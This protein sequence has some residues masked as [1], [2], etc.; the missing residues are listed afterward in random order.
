VR[1]RFL[2][3]L[4]VIA[5]HFSNAQENPYSIKKDTLKLDYRFGG[6][7]NDSL[8]DLHAGLISLNPGG[9]RS[10]VFG[11]FQL[12][13]LNFSSGLTNNFS[14][15]ENN[16]FTY[17]S[18]PHVGFHYSFGSK[19]IQ[20]LNASY[21]QFFSNKFGINLKISRNSMGTMLRNGNFKDNGVD[22]SSIYEGTHYRNFSR[23]YFN[24]I[25]AN[26]NGGLDTSANVLEFPLLFLKVNRENA[27]SIRKN[28]LMSSAHYFDVLKDSLRDVG[29]LISNAW[30]IN[31]REFQESDS[32]N[33][34][35]SQINLDSL[36]TR[37]QFQ[38][39]SLDSK[40][41]AFYKNKQFF[42]E[43]SMIHTYWDYQNLAFHRDTN[44]LKTHF[45]LQY[46]VT[47]K[48]SLASTS[49]FNLM[50]AKGEYDTKFDLNYLSSRLSFAL[51]VEYG[52]K[53]PSVFQRNYFA[54][55]HNWKTSNLETQGKLTAKLNST[56][57]ISKNI[58]VTA[59]I[60]HTNLQ[61]NYFFINDSW[62]NDTL[63]NLSLSSLGLKSHIKLKNL[64]FQPLAIINLRSE[65]LSFIPQVDLRTRIGLNKKIFKAKK[66]DFV[67]AFDLNY[68]SQYQLLDYNNSLDLFQ[69]ATSTNF[70]NDKLYKIDFF[71]G[72]QIELFR[73]YVK[74]ENIDYIWNKSNSFVVNGIPIS[75]FLFRIGLTWDFF[76]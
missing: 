76:N 25:E 26:Q 50:G 23:I 4:L 42:V 75:P 20:I 58:D 9:Y 40:V 62:R 5:V 56:Y 31:N 71:T 33:N 41:G 17:T 49:N 65:E 35:Y 57:K 64:F 74:V 59:F 1:Y 48:I 69:F 10:H 16:K 12:D 14:Q 28:F 32:L 3:F 8:A 21:E 66:M 60:S 6:V 18:L 7:N 29:F 13:Y 61:N 45:E 53:L 52:Q 63:N 68:K 70:S 47:K 24:N 38:V 73:F 34:L 36:N 37:D 22:F 43:A 2:I 15:K 67:I 39:A 44:E 11:N 27:F 51:N 46:K 54:N 55:N 19:A 30:K 72:F